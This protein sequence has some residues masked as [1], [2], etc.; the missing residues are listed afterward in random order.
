MD[1]GSIAALATSLKSASEIAKAMIDLRDATA[2][3]TKV[4]ELTREIMAAQSSA[5]AA[6]TAQFALLEKVRNLEKQV[7]DA[8]AWASEKEKY[9]LKELE[10]GVFARV[11]KPTTEATEPLHAVCPACY[12]SRGNGPCGNQRTHEIPGPRR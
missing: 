3:Q 9:E 1:I 12:R 7:A 11:L 8:E 2:F 4:F 6:Q 10:R 5:L